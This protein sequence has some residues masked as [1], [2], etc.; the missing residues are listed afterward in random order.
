MKTA[1]QSACPEWQREPKRNAPYLLLYLSTI[2]NCCGFERFKN[3][4]ASTS[5]AP[6]QHNKTI[7]KTK[8]PIHN[9]QKQ[10]NN[11]TTA[12]ACTAANRSTFRMSSYLTHRSEKLDFIVRVKLPSLA[13]SALSPTYDTH[14]SR[15]YRSEFN[16]RLMT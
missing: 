2:N 13:V 12:L 14:S 4:S 5:Q 1:A 3:V 7:T 10:P 11:T 8:T 15:R 16:T 9:H 6:R